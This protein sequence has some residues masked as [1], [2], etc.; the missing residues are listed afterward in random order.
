MKLSRHSLGL[1]LSLSLLLICAAVFFAQGRPP[2]PGPQPPLR[3]TRPAVSLN[4]ELAT[5]INELLKEE[6]LAPEADTA[7]DNAYPTADGAPAKPP[8][9]DAPLTALI[10]YWQSQPIIPDG[11]R[12][13]EKTAQRLLE[14]IEARP[15]LLNQLLDKLPVNDET[16]ERL[17]RLYQQAPDDKPDDKDDDDRWKSGL[18]QWLRFNSRYFLAE[19]L[20]AAKQEGAESGND[21]FALDALARLDWERAKPLLL[22]QPENPF[23]VAV[24]YKYAVRAGATALAEKVRAQLQAIVADREAAELRMFALQ[25]LVESDWNG[26]AEWLA[27]LFADTSLTGVNPERKE[28][29]A[30]RPRAPLKEGAVGLVD[31]VEE[32]GER[33]ENYLAPLLFSQ[34]KKLL[35]IVQKLV[36]DRDRNVHNAAVDTL[37]QFL[38]AQRQAGEQA[39]AEAARALLPW[40]DNPAWADGS[41]REAL[42][43]ALPDLK[44]PESASGLLWVLDND[45]DESLRALAAET[46][47]KLK[48]QAAAPAIRRAL[49]RE[50]DEELRQRLVTALMLC[51][52]ISD[53][54]AAAAIEAFA[55]KLVAP[56]GLAQIEAIRKGEEAA[57]LPLQLSIGRILSDSDAIPCPEGLAARLFARVKALRKTQPNV[58]K[59]IL[60]IVQGVPLPLAY[61]FLAE[62]L[63]EGWLDVEALKLAL[64]SAAELRQYAGSEL[65]PLIS[66]GGHAAGVAAVLLNDAAWQTAVLRGKDAKAQWAL[67]AAARYVRTA[68]PVDLVAP[69]LVDKTLGPAAESFLIVEDSTPARRLVWARHPGE[70]LILGEQ[71]PR[72]ESMGSLELLAAREKAARQALK[73]GAA[74]ELF[75]LYGEA[76]DKLNVE[77]RLRKSRA[78]LRLFTDPNVWR[79]RDLSNSELIELQTLA[80]RPEVADLKPETPLGGYQESFA[81]FVRVNKDGGYRVVLEGRKSAPPTLNDASLHEQLSELF[82]RFS[83]AGTYETHYAIEAKL[84]GV[85]VLFADETQQV[86]AVCQE[87]GETLVLAG[88]P[89]NQRRPVKEGPHW[90]LFKEGQLGSAVNA[91]EIFSEWEQIDASFRFL[92]LAPPRGD[93]VSGLPLQF[94]RRS[95]EMSKTL[96]TDTRPANG[97]GEFLMSLSTPDQ[98][99]VVGIEFDQKRGDRRLL[100]RNT[101]TGQQ[102]EVRADKGDNHEPLMP[103]KYLE[104]ANKMLLVRAEFLGAANTNAAYYL[105]DPASGVLQPAKGEFRPL[106]DQA[107]RPLQPTGKPHEFWAVI[108]EQEQSRVGRYDERAFTFTPMLVV[109]G[110]PLRSADVWVDDARG[111]VWLTYKGHLLRLPLPA[112]GK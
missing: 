73:D 24:L 45:E 86:F 106:Q 53:E 98:K 4:A 44:L 52:G 33:A 66:Q 90:R 103:L 36:G 26:Q 68:L 100:R 37:T 61:Q 56:I 104:A 87:G 75:A 96:S 88:A 74:D 105:L 112:P 46:L 11:P 17:Y 15:W 13:S 65:F 83:K 102:F 27:G 19:L 59:E 91:P 1:L 20:E 18:Q 22:A 89:F 29:R 62:R 51:G 71:Y 5:A 34:P 47:G 97:L 12:P 93:D 39:A 82:Y 8:A 48:F 43:G 67:L 25:A 77:I 109:P 63:G 30:A 16:A 85:E 80:A 79:A 49:D 78:Q 23:A 28:K 41:Q 107:L 94:L 57:P 9:D 81:E 70:A 69:L 6:P 108:S 101:Q 7:A 21:P 2:Q 110:L 10:E 72:G 64:D 35:P 111:K 95:L 42:I 92:M 55:R 99:W 60:S 3:R 40:L 14:A 58:A 31:V 32:A 38:F 76:Q 50:K 54:E 84:P